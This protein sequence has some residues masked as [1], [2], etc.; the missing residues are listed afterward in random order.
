MDNGTSFRSQQVADVCSK[1][2]VRRRFRGAYRPSGNGI[3]ER[4]HR[5]IKRMAER[6]RSSPLD[7]V[8]WYNMAPREGSDGATAPS[9]VVS[10]YCWRHPKT[11]P[12]P[13]EVSRPELRVGDTVRVKPPNSRC[14]SHWT[15]GRVTEINL[16]N[17]VEI[18]GMPRHI[19]DIRRVVGESDA[20]EEDPESADERETDKTIAENDVAGRY[21]H[22]S[23]RHPVR[24]RK[25][26]EWYGT[27]VPNNILRL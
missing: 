2:N 15:R 3:V 9:A 27:V 11:R 23:R 25:P 10:K 16:K 4:N 7:M 1:W 19:L 18:D 8:F 24:Q 13:M 20:D 26:P 17:N 12:A 14:T 5:T 21:G 6:T 22:G